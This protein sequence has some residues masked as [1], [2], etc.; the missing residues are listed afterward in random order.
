[1]F[2]AQYQPIK[3]IGKGD[4]DGPWGVTVDAKGDIVV[5][6]QDHNQIIIYSP[7]GTFVPHPHPTAPS[8]TRKQPCLFLPTKEA[9]FL[10]PGTGKK[11]PKVRKVMMSFFFFAFFCS[12]QFFRKS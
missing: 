12:S 1:M 2:D 4:L 6:D 7:D 10:L 9:P 3:I 11:K 5:A 8:P